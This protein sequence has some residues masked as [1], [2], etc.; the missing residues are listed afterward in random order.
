MSSATSCS[1]LGLVHAFFQC[2]CVHI[3]HDPHLFFAV[4]LVNR[5]VFGSVTQTAG[6]RLLGSAV[7]VVCWETDI[8]TS[9]H[10]LAPDVR[11]LLSGVMCGWSLDDNINVLGFL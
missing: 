4:P 11:G 7:W 10:S 3:L 8:A 6:E 2:G 9:W 5:G 1:F